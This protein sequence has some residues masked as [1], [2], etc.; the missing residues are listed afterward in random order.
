M[1]KINVF[2][3]LKWECKTHPEDVVFDNKWFNRHNTTE[4]SNIKITINIRRMVEKC[5]CNWRWYCE[6]YNHD[7]NDELNFPHNLNKVL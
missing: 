7:V 2:E 1:A 6:Y 5:G 3:I 4:N